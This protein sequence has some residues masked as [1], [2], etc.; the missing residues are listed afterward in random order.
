[1]IHEKLVTLI[2]RIG[3]S[4]R[5]DSQTQFGDMIR[6]RSSMIENI[7]KI[8]IQWRIVVAIGEIWKKT[9]FSMH[10]NRD[11]VLREYEYIACRPDIPI[12]TTIQVLYAIKVS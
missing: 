1:M 11:V 5:Y 8:G 2:I 12:I 4:R 10:E 7:L 9:S 6:R 3:F